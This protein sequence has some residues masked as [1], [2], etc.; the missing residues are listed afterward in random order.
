MWVRFLVVLSLLFSHIAI[1]QLTEFSTDPSKFVGQMEKHLASFDRKDAKEFTEKLELVWGN[2]DASDKS[3]MIA[4]S[5]AMAQKKFRPYPEFKA[6]WLSCYELLAG[7][8]TDPQKFQVWQGILEKL[9]RNKQKARFE[10]FLIGST[11]M[12]TG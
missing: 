12:I 1:A 8:K 4:L 2:I 3:R 7:I 5:N 10:E 9:I 6:Y 11:G